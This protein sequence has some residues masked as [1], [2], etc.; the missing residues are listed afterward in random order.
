M[1]NYTIPFIYI[2]SNPFVLYPIRSYKVYLMENYQILTFFTIF[3]LAEAMGYRLKAEKWQYNYYLDFFMH[4]HVY[5]FIVNSLI[6]TLIF[7]IIAKLPKK[8]HTFFN[9]QKNLHNP[10]NT[11][12]WRFFGAQLLIN[13][14]IIHEISCISQH[15]TD[16]FNRMISGSSG[17][18]ACGKAGKAR[19]RRCKCTN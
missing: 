16:K 19:R 8:S 15:C 4:L 13:L 7:S 6:D 11:W 2:F 5:L 3:L 12:F 14:N 18:G 1:N 9:V 17:K 10:L